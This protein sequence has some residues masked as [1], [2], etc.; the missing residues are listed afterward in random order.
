MLTARGFSGAAIFNGGFWVTGGYNRINSSEILAGGV[1]TAG[2]DL[3]EGMGM[4][5]HCL[6]ALNETTAFI[7][8]QTTKH[9]FDD[10][11]SNPTGHKEVG[12][13]WQDRCK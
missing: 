1:W 3:P 2:P 13:S 4:E 8:G 9:F 11:G 6:L 10:P 5:R 12:R 7:V